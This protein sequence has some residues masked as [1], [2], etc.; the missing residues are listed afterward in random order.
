MVLPYMA[1]SYPQCMDHE[2]WLSCFTL[3]NSFSAYPQLTVFLTPSM[4]LDC[5]PCSSASP[6]LLFPRHARRTERRAAGRADLSDHPPH[7]GTQTQRT[8]TQGYQWHC[9]H[10]SAGARREAGNIPGRETVYSPSQVYR[11]GQKTVLWDNSSARFLAGV[12]LWGWTQLPTAPNPDPSVWSDQARW[13]V[14]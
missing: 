4:L 12:S 5:L 7:L 6:P 3:L 9:G 2:C 14:S 1:S 10:V 8:T 11:K 13:N